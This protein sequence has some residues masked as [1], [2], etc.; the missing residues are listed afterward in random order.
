MDAL[1]ADGLSVGLRRSM[2]DPAHSRAD[3]KVS[4]G[5]N[6]LSVTLPIALIACQSA[7]L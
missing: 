7:Q 2:A 4:E 1:G 3:I 5:E 6:R